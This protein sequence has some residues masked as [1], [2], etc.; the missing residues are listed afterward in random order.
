MAVHIFV[1]DEKNFDTCIRHGLAG[2]PKKTGNPSRDAN[3]N[4]GLLSRMAIVKKNDLVLFY[5]SKLKELHGV[6]KVLEYPFYDET[7]VW[8]NED[9][10]TIYPYRVRIDNT[11][12]NFMNP[13]K[14]NDLYD[15]RDNGVLWTFSL[16]RPNGTPNSMFSITNTEYEEIQNLFLKINP[17]YTQPKQIREPYRYFEPNL[18]NQ[19]CFDENLKPRYEYTLMALILNGF[20]HSQYKDIFG[21]YNDFV[22]YVPTSFGKEMDILLLYNNPLVPKQTLAYNIIEVKRDM[23][24]EDGMKQ[25]LQYE[26]WFFMKKV[27]G[28]YNAIRTTAI[29]SGFSDKVKDYL[30]KRKEYEGKEVLLLNYSVNQERELILKEESI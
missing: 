23:F 5:I 4:E 18:R 30:K 10:T 21:E 6:W 8:E 29:A 3:T 25:L 17:F 7:H 2:M 20:A 19:L 15:L 24:D 11:E 14:L 13:I 22:S 26:D 16:I 28:D 12:Y 1:V 9:G 27:N